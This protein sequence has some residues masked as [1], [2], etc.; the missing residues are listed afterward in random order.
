MHGRG[1]ILPHHMVAEV[2]GNKSNE[3][4]DIQYLH[5]A[6]TGKGS[7]NAGKKRTNGNEDVPE[8]SGSSPIVREI[9]DRRVNSI[10]KKKHKGVEVEERR[11]SPNL[12]PC[13]HSACE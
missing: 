5:V 8:E 1:V 6:E 10:A 3:L 7:A 4:R 11:K 9:S 2:D 13:Q 12:L